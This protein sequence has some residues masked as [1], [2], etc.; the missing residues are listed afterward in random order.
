MRFTVR[1]FCSLRM[2]RIELL[3]LDFLVNEYENTIK[4]FILIGACIAASGCNGFDLSLQLIFHKIKAIPSNGTN[5]NEFATG[6]KSLES[7]VNDAVVM[8]VD[9][10]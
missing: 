10:I 4:I 9:M 2:T 1:K 8:S 3:S 6:P 7:I 5:S